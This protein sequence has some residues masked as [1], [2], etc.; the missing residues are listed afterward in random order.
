MKK[1]TCILLS[2]LIFVTPLF[3]R[4]TAKPNYDNKKIKIYKNNKEIEYCKVDN[5]GGVYCIG[6]SS[7]EQQDIYND[8]LFL[9]KIKEAQAKIIHNAPLSAKAQATDDS[10]AA[11]NHILESVINFFIL[12]RD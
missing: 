7:N 4:Y 11:K 10:T 1:F 5:G 12:I 3:A 2:L 9:K 6:M 8:E